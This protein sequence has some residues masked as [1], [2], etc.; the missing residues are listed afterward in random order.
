MTSKRSVL[1][2]FR[3]LALCKYACTLPHQAI[4]Y[5]NPNP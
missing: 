3:Y 5:P 1:S 4:S 2:K